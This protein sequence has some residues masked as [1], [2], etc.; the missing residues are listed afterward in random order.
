MYGGIVP[1]ENVEVYKT[2]YRGYLAF[3]K[4]TDAQIES[5]RQLLVYLGKKYGIPLTYNPSMW[6]VS[7]DAMS[8]KA[9][10]YS[11]T[12]YRHDKSDVHPQKSL[13]SMLEKL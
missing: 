6:E 4:Y 3:E 5:T 2:K 9:G 11:H 8:G 1:T 13:I 12:S 10:V 7:K